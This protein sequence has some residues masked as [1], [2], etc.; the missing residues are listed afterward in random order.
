[1]PTTLVTGSR[2]RVGSTLVRLLHRAGHD[3]RAASRSPEQ[4]TPPTGVPAV[5]CDLSDPATFTA[6]LDGIDSVFLY[7]EPAGI[8]AFVSHAE[9]AGVT[10][11]VLLSSSAVLAPD[12][13]DN[14]IAAPHLAVEQ[15]LAASPVTATFLR[16]GAFAGNAH[17]WAHS[18]RTQGAVDLPYPGSHTSPIDE[19]DVAEAALAVL[20][21]PGLRGS[22]HHLTGPETLTAAEQIEIL[23]KAGGRPVTAHAVS[24]TAWLESVSPFTPAPLAGA[25][26]DYW[27]DSDGIP[28]L[29]TGE[30]ERLTG[31]PARTFT[32]WAEAN[33]AAF[34]P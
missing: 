33:A 15:A 18:I 1:M 8:D 7:A 10:H 9:A 34:R 20:A 32:A 2:G 25:L 26:L 16:P 23:A 31:R 5:A 17:Q 14:P 12:A 3:V 4:L 11:V 30:T 22:A 28:A 6:A 21:D 29:V 19:T 27:A 13:A 24:R